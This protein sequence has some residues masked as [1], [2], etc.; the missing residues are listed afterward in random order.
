M[1]T[2][3]SHDI[4]FNLISP[5][6]AISVY[7]FEFKETNNYIM[8]FNFNSEHNILSMNVQVFL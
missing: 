6:L 8:H 1:Y 2:S 7:P 3:I 4:F 5:F